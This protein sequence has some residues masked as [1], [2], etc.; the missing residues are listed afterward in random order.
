MANLRHLWWQHA[1]REE[2]ERLGVAVHGMRECDYGH[3]A[4]VD[5]SAGRIRISCNCGV[6]GRELER[7]IRCAI[8]NAV[9]PQPTSWRNEWSVGYGTGRDYRAGPVCPHCAP[10][11]R[12]DREA[13]K[14]LEQIAEEN[15]EAR[16]SFDR[17]MNRLE[18]ELVEADRG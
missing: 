13:R 18:R 1:L 10:D 5:T 6:R 3:S 7:A 2:L 15:D 12:R 4:L 14:A 17:W 16:W 8:C 9:V 11:D